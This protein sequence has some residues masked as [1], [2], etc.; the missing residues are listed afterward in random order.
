M[1]TFDSVVAVDDGFSEGRVVG[2]DVVGIIGDGMIVPSV[3]LEM[4]LRES[5]N[6]EGV[7]V[8]T[9]SM[10][11][12]CEW[13]HWHERWRIKICNIVVSFMIGRFH[14]LTEF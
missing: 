2:E 4:E 5:S 12:V 7:V 11:T 10:V 8:M 13:H 1:S 6:I 9:W 14:Q 3:V